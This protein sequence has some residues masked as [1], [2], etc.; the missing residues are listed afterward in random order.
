L[1]YIGIEPGRMHFTWISSAE[2]GKFQ[3]KA[4]EVAEA[5]RELGPFDKLVKNIRPELETVDAGQ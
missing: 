4:K 5:V 1:E 3:T 2:A